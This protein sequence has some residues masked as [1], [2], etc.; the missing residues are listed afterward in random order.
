MD[1]DDGTGFRYYWSIPGVNLSL[2]EFHDQYGLFLLDAFA[3]AQDFSLPIVDEAFSSTDSGQRF[4]QTDFSACCIKGMSGR[5]SV[6]S[7]I[8]GTNGL[9]RIFGFG[10]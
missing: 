4:L 9:V 6:R 1:R 5:Y 2:A 8:S 7:S 3:E 10:Q